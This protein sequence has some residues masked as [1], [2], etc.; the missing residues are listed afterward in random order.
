M[1][2]GSVSKQP[3]E[4]RRYA[5]DYTNALIAADRVQTAVLKAGTLPAVTV[6]TV[7]VNSPYVYFWVSGG[8]DGTSTTIELTVTTALGEVFEDELVVRVRERS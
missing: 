3:G 5:F 6:D 1:R 4:K 7:S 8:A 2:L